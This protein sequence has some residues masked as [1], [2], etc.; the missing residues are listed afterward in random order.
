[1]ENENIFVFDNPDDVIYRYT[2][3]KSNGDAFVTSASPFSYSSGLRGYFGNVLSD[4]KNLEDFLFNA[5]TDKRL[6]G[7]FVKSN[8]DLPDEVKRYIKTI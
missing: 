6:Y 3:V 4:Y 5:K 7:K 1:M 8:D 2:V